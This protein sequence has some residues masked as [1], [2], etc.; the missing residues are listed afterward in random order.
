MLY[1]YSERKKDHIVDVKGN[2][3]GAYMYTFCY[4]WCVK[5]TVMTMII[6]Q[7]LRYTHGMRT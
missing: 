4:G 3:D 7:Q 1:K 5:P 6:I 2:E